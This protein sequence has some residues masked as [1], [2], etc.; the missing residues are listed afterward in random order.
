MA[1]PKSKRRKKKGLSTNAKISIALVVG[2]VAVIAAILLFSGD[3][4]PTANGSREEQLV[5]SDS[6]KLAEGGTDAVLVEFLDFECESCRAA[7]PTVE[8]I[9][10]EYG[11]RMTLV[12]RY[13]PLHASSVNAAKAA[14]AAA[15]QGKFE[16]MYTKLFETQPEWGEQRTP[17]QAKFFAYATELGLDM[18]KFTAVYNDPA[19]EAKIKR[20][21]TDGKAL[22]V[23]A[24]PTFF[25]DGEK[26]SLSGFANLKL[27]VEQAL[28]Q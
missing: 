27:Q 26:L 15:A 8:E 24:T 5:R 28:A 7:H 4:A 12:V 9:R 13:M 18:E 14:E 2:F 16:A 22:G 25:L 11:D 20:D 1:K 17:E 23:Q 10:T 21:E 6:H 19:T 3:D